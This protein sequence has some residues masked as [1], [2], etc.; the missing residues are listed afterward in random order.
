MWSLST[1]HEA[2]HSMKQAKGPCLICKSAKCWKEGCLPAKTENSKISPGHLSTSSFGFQPSSSC[3]ALQFQI[4]IINSEP[5]PIITS[6]HP[7]ILSF[8]SFFVIEFIGWHWLIRSYRFQ[9]YNS[10]IHHLS[11]ALC[12]HHPKSS[13]LPFTIYPP[14]TL[15]YLPTNQILCLLTHP[16]RY[17]YSEG[18]GW[19]VSVESQT[20]SWKGEGR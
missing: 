19:T 20:K 5:L 11:I 8:V 4:D 3:P 13:L 12:V 1:C 17:W 16:C 9:V 15:S 18:S 7:C 6:F 2:W 10:T 14:F